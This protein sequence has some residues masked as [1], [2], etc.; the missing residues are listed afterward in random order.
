MKRSQYGKPP[1]IKAVVKER[2]RDRITI[3]V[4]VPVVKKGVGTLS[5]KF[6]PQEVHLSRQQVR[7]SDWA[8]LQ[9]GDKIHLPSKRGPRVWGRAMTPKTKRRRQ[10]TVRIAGF[11]SVRIG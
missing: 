8:A 10:F 7:L 3:N 1:K 9:P 5:V 11:T 2:N 6:A 4:Q